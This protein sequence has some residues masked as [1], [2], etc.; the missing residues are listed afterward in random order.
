MGIKVIE[1]S[2]K[3]DV[4]SVCFNKPCR[5]RDIHALNLFREYL[6][7]ERIKTGFLSVLPNLPIVAHR[8]SYSL[9]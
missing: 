3:P 4:S 9:K 2:G 5:Y 7:I 6:I 1:I 8:C